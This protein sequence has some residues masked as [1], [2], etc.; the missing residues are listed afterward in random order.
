VNDRLG[1][2]HVG[3]SGEPDRISLVLPS[4]DS[5]VSTGQ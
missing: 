4:G 5:E 1:H 3:I 2:P